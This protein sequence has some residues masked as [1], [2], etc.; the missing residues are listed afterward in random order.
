MQKT[1]VEMMLTIGRKHNEIRELED[2]RDSIYDVVNELKNEIFKR[3]KPK[4]WEGQEFV[5]S[6][7]TSLD[8]P[9]NTLEHM[10][11]GTLP[12]RKYKVSGLKDNHKDRKFRC[13][14]IQL[15]TAYANDQGY[16]L[17]WQMVGKIQ[18][19]SGEYGKENF[20]FVFVDK[21][22]IEK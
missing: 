2:K 1:L 8:Y 20:T 21:V 4:H 18:L 3:F 11:N 13:D 6:N 14:Y 16:F 19:K 10:N 22:E 15:E 12:F 7:N 17:H 5:I 9:M